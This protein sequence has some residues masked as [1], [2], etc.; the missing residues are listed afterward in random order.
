MTNGGDDETE[1][2]GAE[3]CPCSMSPGRRKFFARLS[4]GLGSVIGAIVA[5]PCLGFVLAPIVRRPPRLWREVSKL[6]EIAIGE[7]KLVT[8][9]DSSSLP[10][11]GV[12][13]RT[14]SWLRRESE[15]E[16]IAFSINCRHLGCPVRW[17]EGAELFMCPCHGGV[18][19]KDGTVAAGPPPKALARYPVRVQEGVV[20]IETSPVPLTD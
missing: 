1:E 15:T 10:W 12:T 9:E 14:A 7:T 3:G 8:F 19:Y 2:N 4:I 11:A 20:E 13:A 16:F 6:D 5:L 17:V 18:Y